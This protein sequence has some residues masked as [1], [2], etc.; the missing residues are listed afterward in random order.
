MRLAAEHGVNQRKL[1][2]K[3]D[4]YIVPA[5]CLLY[6]LAFLDRVNISNA[7]VYGMAS[8]LNLVG[9][10]YNTALTIFFVPYILS[11]VPSNYFL[12]KV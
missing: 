9:N 1:M 10:Q 2:L 8:D 4:L 3:A 6:L 7:N 11:E 12:K 5:I